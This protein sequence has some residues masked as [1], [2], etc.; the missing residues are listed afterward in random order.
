[1]MSH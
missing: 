1:M